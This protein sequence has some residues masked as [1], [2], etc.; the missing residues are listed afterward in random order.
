MNLLK[1]LLSVKLTN[2]RVLDGTQRDRKFSWRGGKGSY[3]N[4]FNFCSKTSFNVLTFSVLLNVIWKM[5]VYGRQTTPLIVN[6]RLNC[7][8]LI[9]MTIS[10]NA[11]RKWWVIQNV[12]K[13]I[14]WHVASLLGHLSMEGV[15]VIDERSF[16]R[17]AFGLF[18][19]IVLL[20]SLYYRKMD[21]ILAYFRLTSRCSRPL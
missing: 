10:M 13:R 21:V 15:T 8:G 1:E 18:L 9:L 7:N 3:G 5:S 20:C 12:R 14:I 19:L 4:F 6:V 16:K 11:Y 2:F 17:P